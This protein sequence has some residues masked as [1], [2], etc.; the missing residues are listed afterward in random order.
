MTAGI[1]LN[2]KIAYTCYGTKS[3]MVIK[4]P[5]SKVIDNSSPDKRRKANWAR[6][7]QKVS[8]IHPLLPIRETR[9]LGYCACKWGSAF[10]CDFNRSMQI[11]VVCLC[12]YMKS[13][14][15]YYSSH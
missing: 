7:I 13:G 15:C 9:V 10:G 14:Q 6:P 3:G 4:T 12:F 11:N 8:E 1:L 5:T 2:L